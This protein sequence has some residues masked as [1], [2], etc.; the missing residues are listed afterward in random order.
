MSGQHL[1][2]VVIDHI[3][4][5]KTPSCHQCVTH[6]VERPALVNRLWYREWL[7]ISVG[8]SLLPLAPKVEI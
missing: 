8:K 4:G 5:A 2:V 7:G 3:E 1:P 6:E